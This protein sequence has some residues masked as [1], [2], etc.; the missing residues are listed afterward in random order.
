MQ[1]HKMK[2]TGAR[3]QRRQVLDQFSMRAIWHGKKKEGEKQ[4]KKWHHGKYLAVNYLRHRNLMEFYFRDAEIVAEAFGLALE[5]RCGWRDEEFPVCSL[6]VFDGLRLSAQIKA[7][8]DRK[9]VVSFDEDWPDVHS[10]AM[11]S[12]VSPLRWED[13]SPEMQRKLAEFVADDW[14]LEARRDALVEQL[15][16]LGA[17]PFV[18]AFSVGRL[19]PWDRDRTELKIAVVG[20]ISCR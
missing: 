9:L 16:A 6:P 8:N 2:R 4:C 15:V 3:T 20:N 5:K 10:Q 14:Q 7:L 12:D 11:Q 17:T 19:R 1:K 13:M 18:E